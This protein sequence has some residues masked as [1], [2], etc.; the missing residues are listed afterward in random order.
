[1]GLHFTYDI[2][3]SHKKNFFEKLGSLQKTC[4][5]SRRDS[6]IYGRINIVKTLALSKL[7]F[8]SSLMEIPRNFAAEVNKIVLDFIW[9]QKP[10]KIKRTTL[11]KTKSDCGLGMKDFDLFDKALKLTWV[12]RLCFSSDAP[13]KYI[14]K[15]FLST[16]GGT[17][18]FQCNYSYNLSLRALFLNFT[19]KLFVIGKKS[20]LQHLTARP[21]FCLRQSGTTNSLRLTKKWYI[22]LF[23]TKQV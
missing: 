9:K 7:V 10:A 16:V 2:E 8:I 20:C 5:C 18:L 14:P 17:E 21:R 19:N 12:K 3:L 4:V 13:W 1:M 11:V 23:G 22:Y 6:S 15:S